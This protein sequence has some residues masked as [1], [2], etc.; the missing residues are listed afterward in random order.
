LS[1]TCRH[2]QRA[3]STNFFALDASIAGQSVGALAMACAGM[4]IGQALRL[5]MQP[6]TFQRWFF[7]GLL[8]LGLYLIARSVI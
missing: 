2:D 8:L 3:I 7:V 5:R 1:Q 6:A 4:W